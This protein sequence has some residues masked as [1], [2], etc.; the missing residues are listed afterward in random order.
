M[1]LNEECLLD[2]LKN[3]VLTDLTSGLE[4]QFPVSEEK[5]MPSLVLALV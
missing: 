1:N 5:E 2:Y 3:P 4:A